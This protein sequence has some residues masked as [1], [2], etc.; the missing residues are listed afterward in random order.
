MLVVVAATVLI[1]P[2]DIGF[3]IVGPGSAITCTPMMHPDSQAGLRQC[4]SGHRLAGGQDVHL[5]SHAEHHGRVIARAA[6]APPYRLIAF[7]ALVG[8]TILSSFSVVR[9]AEVGMKERLGRFTKRLDP[10]LH[11]L[12][13]YIE[14]ERT[15]MSMREQVLDVPPQG[16]ITTDN[17]PLKADAVVYWRVFDPVKALYEVQDLT[18]AIQNLVLTQLRSEIGKLTLDETFS[19]RAR[20]NQV[21]LAGLD[22]ATDPWGVKINRVEVRDIIPNREILNSMEMQMAAERTKRAQIIKSEGE[23]QALLN[24]ASG[25]AE[26]AKLQA[27]GEKVAT[28]FRAEA[29]KE[30]LVREAEGAAAS[31][32]LLLEACNGDSE[33]ATQLQLLK[34]YINTQGDIAKSDNAKVLLFP[35][36]EDW[37]AKAGSM[38]SALQ[39]SSTKGV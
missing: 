30:R 22:E 7:A 24:Q 1:V 21:L 37:A 16:C 5:R 15:R 12:I 10:G 34:A 23:K 25:R 39:S 11:F 2:S 6:A 31:F 36:S 26:A 3:T 32:R 33:R 27:E 19:A 14:V 8:W 13:P 38:L 17:A 28:I 18:I 20:I 29:E 9:Q 4:G 35:S